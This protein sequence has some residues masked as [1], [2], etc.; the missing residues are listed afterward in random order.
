MAKLSPNNVPEKGRIGEATVY[1]RNGQT[2]V[3]VKTRAKNSKERTTLVMNRRTRWRNVQNAWGYFSKYISDFFEDRQPNQTA[4]NRFMSLNLRTAMV[5]LPK[6][7]NGGGLVVDHFTI[8]SGTLEPCV[9]VNTTSEHHISSLSIGDLQVDA[10]TTVARFSE[11]LSGLPKD[12]QTYGYELHFFRV[13]QELLGP[14]I[15]PKAIVHHWSVTT[16]PA[17]QRPLFGVLGVESAGE[18]L[19]NIEGKLG[20]KQEEGEFVAWV[21]AR[22][23]ADGRTLVTTQRLEGSSGKLADFSSQA[24]RFNAI[25]S[26]SNVHQSPSLTETGWSFDKKPQYAPETPGNAAYHDSA[27]K[28]TISTGVKPSP[29]AGT[30]EGGGTYLLSERVTLKAHPAEGYR[31]LCW[32]DGCL[33]AERIINPNNYFTP[34]TPTTNIA[35]AAIFAPLS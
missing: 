34:L 28:F 20:A 21:V 32:D 10:N 9:S 27:F 4:Y 13:E 3:R 19:L 30:V 6:E 17:D 2:I 16:N 7:M 15:C 25:Y 33:E 14:L 1:Q 29:D 35:L 8:S 18:G 26:Y 11:C 24:A 31:F 22:R 12:G 23:N 5:Y